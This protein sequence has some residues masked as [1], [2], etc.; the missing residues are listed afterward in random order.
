MDK[1]DFCFLPVSI[2]IRHRKI[3]IVGGGKV[4]YHKAL[5]LH[6]FTDE[7]TVLSL[8]FHEGFESLPF[9]RIQKAYESRD[10]EGAWL[11]YICTENHALNVRIKEDAERLHILASVCDNPALCDFVSPAV[12]KEGDLT[13]S[14][15]S[16]ARDVRRSIRVRDAIRAAVEQGNLDIR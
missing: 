4:G 5:I 1:K 16:N 14:V 2:N 6:R 11:V 8:T 3:L 9:R 12:Y 7:V 15:S 13:V 10:L